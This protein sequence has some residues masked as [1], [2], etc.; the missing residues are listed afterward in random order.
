M[1]ARITCDGHTL[2]DSYIDKYKV[3]EPKCEIEVNK[4]GTLSFQIPQT[5][6]HYGDLFSISSVIKYYEDDRLVFKG[7]FM[8]EPRD[9]YNTLKVEC[10]GAWAYLLDSSQTTYNFKDTVKKYVQLLIDRH[11]VVMGDE[12]EK[13]FMVGRVTVKDP[14]GNNV[15]VRASSQYPQTYD[16]IEDKLINELDGT[17]F[18]DYETMT[19]DY[20]AEEDL[21]VSGQT[22]KF[23]ENLLELEQLINRTDLTTILIPHGAKIDN[24][25]S[26]GNDIVDYNGDP[27]E[28]RVDI[29]SVNGGKEY[30]VSDL[31]VALFGHIERTEV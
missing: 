6:P 14:D 28:K 10:E 7:R 17:F 22:I 2:Y 23:A 19:I 20:L 29:K 18:L 1:R 4:S 16:E 9:F 31:G 21:P 13:K 26:A 8:E 24:K 12:D 5:H 25:D 27:V 30:I 3:I 15:L 11:N